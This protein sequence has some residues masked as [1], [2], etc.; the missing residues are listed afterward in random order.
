MD[1]DYK[2]HSDVVR[3]WTRSAVD[4]YKIGCNCSRCNI[5]LIMETPCKMKYSVLEL[6]KKFGK[7]ITTKGIIEDKET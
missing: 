1:L 6:V 5:P 7:P 2:L 3:R 4:C